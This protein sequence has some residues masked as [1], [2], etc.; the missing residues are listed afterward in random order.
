[1]GELSA[2]LITESFDNHLLYR[3]RIMLAH[4]RMTHPPRGNVRNGSIHVSWQR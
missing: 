4:Y 1:M 2:V 3:M